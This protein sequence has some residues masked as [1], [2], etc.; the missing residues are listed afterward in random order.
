MRALRALEARDWIS[1]GALS[2][3]RLYEVL[4]VTRI[5][6]RQAQMLFEFS[7]GELRNVFGLKLHLDFLWAHA[8]N[9]SLL[10]WRLTSEFTGLRGFSRRSG[11]MICSA[12]FNTDGAKVE[13]TQTTDHGR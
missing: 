11:G 3:Q 8:E 9:C 13:L 10:M 5:D 2:L 4:V 12:I 7:K 1:R 6:L